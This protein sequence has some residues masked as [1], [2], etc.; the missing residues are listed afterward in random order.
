[1]KQGGTIQDLA[2]EVTRVARSKHDVVQDTPK[3]EFVA[4]NG[5][6]PRL[7][8]DDGAQD[9]GL[10]EFRLRPLAAEQIGDAVGVPRRYWRRME[11]EAPGLLATNVNHWFTN[12]PK[13]RL[14]RTLDGEVRAYLSDRYLRLDN[15][16][17]AQ[18]LLPVL[19]EAGASIASCALTENHMYIKATLESLQAPNPR[20]RR[21]GDVVFA[22]VMIQN[23]EVGLGELQVYPLTEVLSCTN[24]QVWRRYG[25][26]RRHVGGRI[27]D[28][29][30]VRAVLSAE[31]L[32][33]DD[34]AYWLKARDVVRAALAEEQFRQLVA[35]ITVAA[36]APQMAQPLKGVE[37]LANQLELADDE[38]DGVLGYL[39]QG[40]DL[41]AWG[42]ANALT[43]YSQD[44]AS[45]DRATELEGLADDVVAMAATGA[46]REVA[47]V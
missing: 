41:S 4:A 23:S 19:Q 30:E 14:V 12:Q 46:W 6:G 39:V 24:G 5:T 20:P 15:Y 11:A 31:A 33:A 35:E 25:S 17:I 45:Y 13:R 34:H 32:Q 44:V 22:G 27:K 38:A 36:D 3:M 43:R 29:D 26:S 10:G 28:S 18:H 40:G 9:G 42:A 16:D 21:V 8:I 1:M 7:A 37:V 47:M 2:A